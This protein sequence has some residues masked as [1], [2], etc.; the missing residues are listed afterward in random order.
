MS[1]LQGA[2]A[3]IGSVFPTTYYLTISRGAFSK[4]LALPD[5]AIWFAPLV[6]MLVVLVGLSVALLNKQEK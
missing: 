3:V 2:G 4:A 6:V 5:L 1:S